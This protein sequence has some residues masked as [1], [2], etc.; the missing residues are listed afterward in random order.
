M[1]SRLLRKAFP[2]LTPGA[3]APWAAPLPSQAGGFVVQSLSD[4]CTEMLCRRPGASA[5]T[6]LS[7]PKTES[8]ISS[9]FL[10]LRAPCQVSDSLSSM[11]HL[12]GFLGKPHP[13]TKVCMSCVFFLLIYPLSTS[14]LL[15]CIPGA[16]GGTWIIKT[17]TFLMCLRREKHSSYKRTREIWEFKTNRLASGSSAGTWKKKIK[18]QSLNS[19]N[20]VEVILKVTTAWL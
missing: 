11:C 2:L 3:R 7:L 15:P 13:V 18:V 9:C 14:C 16:R 6:T 12:L 1:A 20:Q 4:R 19:T 10:L 8:G 17:L 5:P